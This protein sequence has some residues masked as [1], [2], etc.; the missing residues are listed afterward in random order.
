MKIYSLLFFLFITFPSLS[1]TKNDSLIQ[2]VEAFNKLYGYVKY[3]HPSDEAAEL[4]WDAFAI[5]GSN[6]ILNSSNKSPMLLLLA[7]DGDM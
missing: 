7:F 3:F 4:D 5:Y 2:K 6:E 1:N